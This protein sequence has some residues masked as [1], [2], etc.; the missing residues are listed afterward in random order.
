M[1]LLYTSALSW[2]RNKL[3]NRNNMMTNIYLNV[4][5]RAGLFDIVSHH[6]I[7]R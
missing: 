3:Q 4:S 6:H 1:K 7:I 5:A 2:L